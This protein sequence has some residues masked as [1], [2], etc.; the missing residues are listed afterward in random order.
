MIE[1]RRN[2]DLLEELCFLRR[3]YERRGT[4]DRETVLSPT[5]AVA[6]GE[7]LMRIA[8]R[9]DAARGRGRGNARP[10]A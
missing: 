9:R 4:A 2:G 10:A 1:P 8:R 3:L 6:Y 5:A 7:M